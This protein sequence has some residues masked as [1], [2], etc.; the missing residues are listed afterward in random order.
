MRSRT[1]P[2]ATRVLFTAALIAAG[3]ASQDP[4]SATWRQPD[5]TTRLPEILGGGT[6]ELDATLELDGGASPATFE[7]Y[8]NLATD[9]QGARLTDTIHAHGTY[10]DRG[11]QLVLSVTGFTIPS[12]SENTAST[13]E[14]GSQCIILLGFAGTGVCFAAP[15][16][17]DYTLSGDTLT[18]TLVHSIAGQPQ[19]S[20]SFR[21]TRAPEP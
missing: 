14:D 15:Q 12:G 9:F 13:L 16:T 4:L 8:L 18:M 5:A 11:D 3:C 17:S 21:F 7:L 20:T 1:T 2:N 6:L 19:S 10:V